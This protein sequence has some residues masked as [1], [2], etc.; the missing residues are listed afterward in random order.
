MG[1]ENAQISNFMKTHK[2]GGELFHAD[3][4]AETD[5]HDEA[6]SCFSQ[7]FERA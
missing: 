6:N 5:R 2:A 1:W 3:A 4:R 7:F